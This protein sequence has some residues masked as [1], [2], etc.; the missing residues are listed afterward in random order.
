[1]KAIEFYKTNHGEHA[2]VTIKAKSFVVVTRQYTETCTVKHGF[3]PKTVFEKRVAKYGWVKLEDTKPA[4]AE[5]I[6]A[7]T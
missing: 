4:P 3:D 5:S 7:T 1:M 6:G 2:C